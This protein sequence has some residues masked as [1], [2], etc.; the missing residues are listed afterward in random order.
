MEDLDFSKLVFTEED[1]ALFAKYVKSTRVRAARNISGF[2]LPAGSSKEDRLAVEAVLK[3]AFG[4][5]PDELKGTYYPLGELSSEQEDAL[6]AGGFLF[7][8]PGRYSIG[9]LRVCACT[10]HGRAWFDLIFFWLP[11]RAQPRMTRPSLFDFVAQK[12]FSSAQRVCFLTVS[13][14]V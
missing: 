13:P 5:L 1:A 11:C 10:G 6:Q 9:C 8:K 3:E 7:Q 2:S 12:N 4:N 14:R